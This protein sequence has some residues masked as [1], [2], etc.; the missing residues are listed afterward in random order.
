MTIGEIK[1]PNSIPN[2]N[3]N[4][5]NGV[6]TF[7][8]NNPKIKKIIAIIKDQILIFSSLNKGNIET[9]K[10][11]RKNTIPKLLFELILILFFCKLRLM[12]VVSSCPL[13]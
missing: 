2:L 5:F 9:I 3:H 8:F 13:F 1:L 7:E 4:L 11:N 12:K 6:K 10:K